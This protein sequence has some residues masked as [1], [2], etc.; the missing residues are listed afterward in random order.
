[1]IRITRT[2]T[3]DDL[4]TTAARVPALED[5]LKKARIARDRR[6]PDL[7]AE[8]A[9]AREDLGTYRSLTDDD[10]QL[11]GALRTSLK[12]REQDH[13]EL[14]EQLRRAQEQV[15]LDHEDRVVLRT[16]L[17]TARRQE[18][19]DRDTVY[20]LYRRGEL[21]SVHSSREGAETAAEGEGAAPGGWISVP[22]GAPRPS[23]SDSPAGWCIEPVRLAA[24]DR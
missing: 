9:Q 23:D 7:E 5:A 16:L 18:E 15:L 21:H 8:L 13:T 2:R 20:L 17:R 6:V 14:R 22:P 19:R 10:A 12:E 4:T 24:T 11:I 1:M 3:I